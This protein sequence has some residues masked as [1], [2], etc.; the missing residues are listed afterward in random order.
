MPKFSS[1]RVFVHT[2]SL[3]A[4]DLITDFVYTHPLASKVSSP[5][6]VYVAGLQPIPRFTTHSLII[7][8]NDPFT[9]KSKQSYHLIPN[10]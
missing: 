3:L 1:Q 4:K 8:L 7:I 6:R 9:Q 5:L 10:Q 2:T